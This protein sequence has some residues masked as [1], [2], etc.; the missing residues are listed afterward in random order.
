MTKE[1]ET[2]ELEELYA[3]AQEELKGTGERLTVWAG[4]DAVNQQ[5]A[6]A[7][8]FRTR[9]PEVPIDIKVEL[10]KIHD[11]KI[12]EELLNGDLTPDVTMLQT[13]NDFEDWKKLGVLEAFKPVGFEQIRDE[14][15]DKDGE[16]SAFRMFA[17]LPQYAKSGLDEVPESLMD[18]L[19]SNYQDKLILTY[20]HDD[21]AV[22]YVYDEMLKRHGESFL[23]ELAKLNPVFI[24]GTAGPPLLVGKH[25]YLGN[26]TGYE[27]APSQPS[28]SFIPKS[29]FFISWGQRIAMFKLTKHKAAARLFLAFVQSLEFQES[30]GHYTVRKDIELSE[31]WIGDHATTNPFGFYEFMRDRKHIGELRKLMQS[32]FGPVYGDSPVVDHR[33]IKLTYGG[34]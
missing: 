9:F 27:T 1:L 26:L 30:L 34:E 20:P 33:M 3:L 11:V 10:S 19:K 5:D 28:Q 2:K 22:L 13:S 23:E 12:Y 25:G 6:V 31:T 24:R 14:F 18:M 15:K 4:G 32:Y 21:D 29:D 8:A 16:F 17:F 7:E